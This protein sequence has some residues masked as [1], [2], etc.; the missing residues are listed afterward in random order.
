MAK[1]AWIG[2]GVMGTH[3][4]GHLASKS[5]HQII[6]YNRTTQKSLDWVAKFGGS[7]A[8]SP[9]QASE[10]ADF[11]F[12]CVGNDKDLREVTLGPNGA[13]SSL[14]PGAIFIDHTSSS[15]T[16]AREHDIEA[17]D[18]GAQFLDAPYLAVKK[19]H[20]TASSPL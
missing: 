12:C 18:K 7:H 6:V 5:D 16:I 3:M 20:K 17:Q 1:I 9:L 15:A 4:A 11:V 14:K 19:A 10:G 2:L 13:F 8:L